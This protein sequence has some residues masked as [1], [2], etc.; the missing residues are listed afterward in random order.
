[1]EY[2]VNKKEIKLDRE[3]N[4]LDKFVIDFCKLLPSYVIVSGYVSILF[5][6]SRATEDVDLL[7]PKMSL[8]DFKK[9]WS[10]IINA[11]FECLN[12]SNPEEGF[13]MLNDHAIRFS[14]KNK[15]LPNMKF[16]LIKNNIEEYSF[17]NKIKAVIKKDSLFISPLEMQIAFKLFLAKG[18]NE[19]DIEDA[20]HIYDLFNE[21]LKKEELFRLIKQLN[22]EKEF[23]IIK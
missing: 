3:L 19:K 14:R 2:N 15:P 5:G 13:N 21:K 22:S 12:T 6:R 20:K 16:K 4:N 1:M 10:K 7:L 17:S 18:G 9:I 23:E 8:E 11:G